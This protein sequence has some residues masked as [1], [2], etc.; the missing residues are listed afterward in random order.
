MAGFPR[1]PVTLH[2]LIDPR[3]HGASCAGKAPLFDTDVDGETYSHKEYRHHVAARICRICPVRNA[4]ADAV[5]EL[6]STQRQGIWSGVDI[7]PQSRK[8]QVA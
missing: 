3:L 1:S 7:S 5:A 2:A 4:C 8:D 6:P